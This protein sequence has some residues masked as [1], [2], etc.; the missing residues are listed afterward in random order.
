MISALKPYPAY[1]E[2]GVPWLEEVPKHWEVRR[3]KYILR[4]QDVRSASGTEQLL[5][6]SQ[7]TGV[8]ERKRTDGV[9]EPDT[10]AES[11]VGYKCVRPQELVINIML[12]WNGSMGVS[13]YSGIV[14]PA[15]CVYRFNAFAHPRYFHYLLRSPTYKARIKAVS[16]GVV[17]S[18][19]R[20]KRES[21]MVPALQPGLERRRRQSAQSK[22][23]QNRFSLEA[24]SHAR[25][26]DQH[27]GELR[28]DCRDEG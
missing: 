28:P 13:G 26:S 18:R 4:E 14:S 10:R 1:K 16:T 19:L 15:Y 11:L 24:Y 22:R 8:T 21:L 23:H 7:Y 20:F 2:S 12:A 17:E 25:W 27:C 9:D 5:R 3:L 6:V